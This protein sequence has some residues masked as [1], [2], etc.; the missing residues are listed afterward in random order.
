MKVS[1][2]VTHLSH[3]SPGSFYR[4][5][6]MSKQLAKLKIENDIYTPFTEDVKN[7]HDASMIEI[8]GFGQKLNMSNFLYG[9]F[10]KIIYNNRLSRFISY[11]KLIVKLSD[12]L[13]NKMKKSIAS[14]A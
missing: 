8:K 4:P 6:E 14:N 3:G 7:I 2:I 9:T 10:R 5:Y 13:S 12:Q 11:D 1:F